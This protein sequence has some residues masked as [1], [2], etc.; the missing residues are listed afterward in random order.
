MSKILLSFCIP[1]Y[2]RSDRIKKIIEQ[3]TS[4]KSDEIE[5]VI[6]DNASK[7]DT[8]KVVS[9]FEDKRIK[10]FRNKTNVGMD[11]NFILAIKRATG[12]FIFL[13][14]DE[15]EVE[16]ETIPWI[17]S[18]IRK[19]NN[20]SQIFLE[21]EETLKDCNLVA[22]NTGVLSE[23]N[24]HAFYLGDQTLCALQFCGQDT[25]EFVRFRIY[26]A[27]AELLEAKIYEL[28]LNIKC[29]RNETATA[30][31]FDFYK[32]HAPL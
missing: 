5:I 21:I 16:L 2:N 18:E 8:K 13:L 24:T 7:D 14:M 11:G 26:K 3:I 31:N 19:N 10:Y 29:N 15:D 22:S 23:T 9:K 20:L 17:L 27:F 32:E 4:F 6:S 30:I 12:K 28:I 1:V 25:N